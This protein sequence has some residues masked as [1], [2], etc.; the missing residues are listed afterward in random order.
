MQAGTAGDGARMALALFNPGAGLLAWSRFTYK[1]FST[2]ALTLLK[3]FLDPLQDI[4]LAQ[5]FRLFWA[6][7]YDLRDEFTA[8]VTSRMRLACGGIKVMFGVDNPWANLLYHQCAATAE[9]GDGMLR[10]TV[11]IF[12]QIP[13]AK[14]VCKDV[15]GRSVPTA[16]TRTCAP[17]LPVSLLPTLYAITNTLTRAQ[18]IQS[19]A[20]ERVLDRVKANVAKALDPFFAHAYLALD[21]LG[22]S[23]EYV[24][25]TFDAKAG[26][27]LDFQQDPHIVV[28]VPQPVDYFQRC[29]GTSMCR[30]ACSA[31]WRAFQEAGSQ[32]R[33]ADTITVAMESMFF[34]GELDQDLMLTNA[35]ASVELPSALG[36]AC[37]GPRRRCRTW[38][39]PWPR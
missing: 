26:R 33:G 19:M 10:L 28:I 2:L 14:C 5:A 22:S 11:D 36:A 35:S 18:P 34:P 6:N 12:V 8:T 25:A 3:R 16:V 27:C 32:Q 4:T 31:E 24:T 17:P 7:L 29:A 37:C 38:P 30:Q 39:W 15:S 20:C 13:M 1:V 23:V 21:A 9:L